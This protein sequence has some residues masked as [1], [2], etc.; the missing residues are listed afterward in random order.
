MNAIAP[1]LIKPDGAAGMSRG[2]GWM[3]RVAEGVAL[4]R[5]GEVDEVAQVARFLASDAASYVTGAVIPVDGG[6]VHQY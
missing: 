6:W 2:R 5:H 1:G 4:G 3:S